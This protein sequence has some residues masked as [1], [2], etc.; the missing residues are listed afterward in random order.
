MLAIRAYLATL[1]PVASRNKPPELRWPLSYRGL[2]RAWNSMFFKPG[3]FEPDQ[4]QSAAWNQGGYLVPGS[5]IAAPATRR[6][7]GFGADKHAQALSRQRG[8][9]LVRATARWRRAQRAE[10]VERRGHHRISAERPQRQQL[11]PAG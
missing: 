9:R 8:R 6:R 10:I 1:A 7:T 5:A 3:L 11:M 2:M 4:S